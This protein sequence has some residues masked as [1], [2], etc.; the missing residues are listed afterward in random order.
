MLE[1]VENIFGI[2]KTFKFVFP[3]L[4]FTITSS[5][6]F[7]TSKMDYLRLIL[8]E[9]LFLSFLAKLYFSNFSYVHTN[10]DILDGGL[11]TL[12]LGGFLSGLLAKPYLFWLRFKII[13]MLETIHKIDLIVFFN[14]I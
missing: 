3:V 12:L 7:I 10:S 2:V 5:N 11:D 6:T 9:V 14:L 13:E 4:D 8:F 1:K